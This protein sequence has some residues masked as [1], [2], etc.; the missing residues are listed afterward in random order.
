MMMQKKVEIFVFRK[1]KLIT[2]SVRHV[3]EHHKKPMCWIHIIVLH[4]KNSKQKTPVRVNLH[5]DYSEC[6]KHTHRLQS[7]KNNTRSFLRLTKTSL[8][9][10]VS[11]SLCVCALSKWGKKSQTFLPLHRWVEDVEKRLIYVPITSTFFEQKV[12]VSVWVFTS[13]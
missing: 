9:L 13:R 2:R 12:I 3:C 6:A 11:L 7:T 5:I 1:M 4:N 8:F 10:S